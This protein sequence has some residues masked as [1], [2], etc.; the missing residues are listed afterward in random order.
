MLL[1]HLNN[2][3]SRWMI[4]CAV[5]ILLAFSFLISAYR[6]DYTL[7]VPNSNA[8]D[9]VSV[10]HFTPQ[11]TDHFEPDVAV[12]WFDLA[13][14]L[15]RAERLSPPVAARIYGYTGVTLYE[16]VVPGMPDY[17]SLAGQLNGLRELPRAD[18]R[19][20]H[21]PTVANSALA[22][23][24]KALF[25]GRSS[26]TLAEIASLEA[27]F[28]GQF[29]AELPPG[30]FK[31][32]VAYGKAVGA[33]IATWSRADGYQQLHNCAYTP[34]AGLGLWLPTPPG[35][36]P[37]LEPC[38]G[39]MR[40]FVLSAGD[41]CDPGPP[42]AYSEDTASSFFLEAQEV[43]DAVN[44]LTAEQAAIA[45]FWADNPGQTG[46]PP[47][48]S[49]AIVS[50]ILVQEDYSLDVAAEAYASVGMAVA[51]AF[52][53]CWSAKYE[54]NL[55]RPVTYIQ[56]HIDS[57]WTPLIPT[58][59]FPEYTSGHS[60]QSAAA[61]HVLTGLFGDVPF[62]DHTHDELGL[63]PRS[64]NTFAEFA[65]EAAISRLYGGIHFRPAIELGLVQ[66]QCVGQAV[67]ALQFRKP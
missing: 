54:Y 41:A 42:T 45:H 10:P 12:A 56:S 49:I 48:H 34:P 23:T 27:H 66:G 18:G 65:A 8:V 13:Y 6:A 39:Q 15:V 16:A 44:N 57:E 59:P 21:W 29:Q 46:T 17:Q 35:F 19:A 32:S 2:T 67:R 55:L 14:D 20:Y 40:P 33:A 31:R 11:D 64:F 9:V 52:I 28:A 30:I 38:W 25:A 58:P 51:D 37:P 61:A 53:S 3:R 36:A 1:R 24:L 62:T 60:V 7:A 43:Y 50:Q 47:G 63:P 5:F 26:T 22:T 4:R